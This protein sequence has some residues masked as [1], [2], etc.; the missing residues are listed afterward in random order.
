MTIRIKESQLRKII[1]EALYE[2]DVAMGSQPQQQPKK[3]GPP[4]SSKGSASSEQ[5]EKLKK[6]I[7]MMS[8]A[9]SKAKESLESLNSKDALRWSQ[10][11]SEFAQHVLSVVKQQQH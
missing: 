7:N 9:A 5:R 1:Q 10:K 11:T 3:V 8:D 6:F 2:D 4:D